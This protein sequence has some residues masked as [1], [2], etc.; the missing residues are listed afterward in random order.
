M[1]TAIKVHAP[2]NG[3]R[4]QAIGIEFVTKSVLSYQM[5]PASLSVQEARK[6]ISLLEIAVAGTESTHPFG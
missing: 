2:G 4:A 3:S 5:V 1:N 6:L